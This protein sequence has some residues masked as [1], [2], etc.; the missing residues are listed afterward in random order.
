MRG[1]RVCKQHS[2]D[3]NVGR[4]R[5]FT[6]EV[7]A[8]FLEAIGCGV[9]IDTAAAFAGV[10]ASTVHNR[11]TRGEQ[12]QAAGKTSEFVEFLE[13]LTR[14]RASVHVQL[15]SQIQ[16]A[17]EK[18]WRA[19]AWMLERLAPDQFGRHRVAEDEHGQHRPISEELLGGR[20]PVNVPRETREKII[21]LLEAEAPIEDPR[22]AHE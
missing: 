18:D 19:N 11:I 15:A 7:R 20:Q 14:T 3:A 22:E 12:E 9:G 6:P 13:G 5:K 2:G 8:C 16:R 1:R 10:S 17:G 21:A 4:R